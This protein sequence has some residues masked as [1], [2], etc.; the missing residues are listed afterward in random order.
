MAEEE[1]EKGAEKNRKI[2]NKLVHVM[3]S[4]SISDYKVDH[5]MYLVDLGSICSLIFSYTPMHSHL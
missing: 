4:L 1:R 5:I 2:Q 3:F